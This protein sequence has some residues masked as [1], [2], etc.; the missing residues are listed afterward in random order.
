MTEEKGLESSKADMIGRYVCLKGGVSN[1]FD[2]SSLELISKLKADTLLYSNAMAKEG[3]DEMELLL[4]YCDTMG[5][6]DQVTSPFPLSLSSF[7]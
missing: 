5:I 4:K 7:F 2:T 3:I 1:R 6:S